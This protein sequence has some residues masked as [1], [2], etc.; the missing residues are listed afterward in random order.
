MSEGTSS[1]WVAE[2]PFGPLS[3]D[4]EWEPAQPL[5]MTGKSDENFGAVMRVT[6]LPHNPDLNHAGATVGLWST[7]R[8]DGTHLAT[9][10]L[11]S[12][13]VQHAEHFA[14]EKGGEWEVSRVYLSTI[15]GP[16]P[17]R[18]RYQDDG[19]I[20]YLAPKSDK[21]EM[22]AELKPAPPMKRLYAHY[23]YDTHGG[24]RSPIDAA[25]YVPKAVQA[26]GTSS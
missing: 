18:P 7:R 13:L 24:L 25:L 1:C 6:T 19:A 8:H 11:I 23:N 22:M 5:A 12:S 9:W 15:Y 20:V 3:E 14:V 26:A 10:D 17:E 2:G 4:H 21:A 16:N